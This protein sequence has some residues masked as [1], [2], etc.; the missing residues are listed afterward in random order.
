MINHKEKQARQVDQN[1]RTIPGDVRTELTGIT[2]IKEKVLKKF[3]KK[4][5]TN[6]VV[7]FVFQETIKTIFDDIEKMSN[8]EKVKEEE[9]KNFVIIKPLEDYKELKKKYTKHSD[10]GGY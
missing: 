10:S 2:H 5:N 8:F 7:E 9:D 1:K 4:W 3:S 6:E